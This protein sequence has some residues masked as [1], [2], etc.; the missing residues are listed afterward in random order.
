MHEAHAV[1]RAKKISLTFDDPVAYVTA[2][3]AQMPGARPSMLL[4]HKARRHSELE[5]INGQ[6]PDLGRALGIPTPYNDML[7]AVLRQ[8]EAAFGRGKP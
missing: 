4:D 1:A 2:F 3:G 5:A 7:V 8:R 6:V